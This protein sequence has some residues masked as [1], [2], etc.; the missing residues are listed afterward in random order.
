MITIYY[1]TRDNNNKYVSIKRGD[2]A[3]AIEKNNLTSPHLVSSI[4]FFCGIVKT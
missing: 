1:V 4:H 2:E 3:V